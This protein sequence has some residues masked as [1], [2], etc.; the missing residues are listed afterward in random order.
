ML[1]TTKQ[2]V[3]FAFLLT[4]LLFAQ[5]GLYNN[6]AERPGLSR[7]VSSLTAVA[8]VALVYAVVN[9]ERF[10][11]YYI[12]YGSLF[13][14]VAFVASFRFAYELADRR[15]PAR[16]RLRA[17]GDPRR[18][19]RPHRE[20]GPGARP[21]ARLDPRRRL[22]VAAAAL[23]RRPALARALRGP[24]AARD[25]AA[26]RRGHHRRPRLPRAAGGRARG[27][28]PPAR[29]PRARRPLDDGDPRPA[30]GVHP[31]ASPSRSSS[32]SRPSS[33][34]STTSSSGPST[35]SARRCS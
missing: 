12:F 11:S 28:L 26:H 23:E 34:A 19:R 1:E 7:I 35:S 33:R 9:G 8:A 18:Q 31:R 24:A 2:Y 10:S 13:F 4:A 22:R 15:D 30:G 20:R 17:P 14:A 32:S 16:R 3:S 5:S 6:R 29:R 27:R 21:R 25:R